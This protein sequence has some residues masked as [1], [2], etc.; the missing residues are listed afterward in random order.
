MRNL[1]TSGENFKNNILIDLGST[2]IKYFRFDSSG[3]LS[4]SGY[5]NRDYNKIIGD[6]AA[7]ILDEEIGYNPDN[8]I[9]KICSSANGGLKT[10]I[11]G[12]TDRFST[13]W[14]KKS[15]LNSGA[16]VLW[17]SSLDSIN[18]NS[19][20]SVDV[21]IIAG[22]ANNSQISKQ[23]LW[24]QSIKDVTINYETIIFSGN[25]L[26]HSTARKLWSNIV[27]SS[28]ILGEDLCWS[29]EDLVKILRE[30][31]LSDLVNKKGI[32]NI[33]AFSKSPIIPTPAVVQKSFKAVI[34]LKTNFNF[35]APLLMLDIGG[36]TTDL[37]FGSE[38]FQDN[39]GLN[40]KPSTN[41]YVY[42]DLGVFAS[43]DAL[44]N[45]L[46]LSNRLGNFLRALDPSLAEK[47]YLSL[48]ENDIEWI[49]PDFLAEA[50]FFLALDSCHDDTQEELSLNLR[51]VACIL[52][53]GG[54][55]QLCDLDR[56]KRIADIC[57]ASNAKVI[58]DDKYQIWME[59]MK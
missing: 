24:L 17:S 19:L 33:Q 25:K 53:T 15:A 41:R 34:D 42:T 5:F 59:G 10:G 54:A 48:R 16:N 7:K 20:D 37:F 6:Q 4:D 2:T 39:G 45:K 1:N 22:G 58:L 46:S 23:I 11:I 31:Y 18:N 28:N 36:A 35:S 9:I 47:K 32:S 57:G 27:F 44:I 43:R 12:Y 26:L 14:A 13:K 50:C 38:L 40:P 21:L 49:T 3:N 30:A 51:Q 55:S 56:L 29:G 8:D 52:I